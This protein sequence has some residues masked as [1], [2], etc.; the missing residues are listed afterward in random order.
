MAIFQKYGLF[1]MLF[2]YAEHFGQMTK[3]GG[4][5]RLSDAQF[6]RFMNI[7]YQCGVIK[8]VNK[9]KKHFKGTKDAHKLDIEHFLQGKK[10]TQLTGNLPPEALLKEMC[11]LGRDHF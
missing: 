6:R 3:E 7:I 8:G 10:L 2:N 4:Q 1:P 5:P 9:S 11:K